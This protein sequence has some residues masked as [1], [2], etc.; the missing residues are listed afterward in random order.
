MYKVGQI[1][2]VGLREYLIIGV[3]TYGKDRARHVKD[4]ML[5]AKDIKMRLLT[6]I[7]SMS[8][9][10]VTHEI[11]TDKADREWKVYSGK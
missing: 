5:K 1:V 7:D 11:G 10:R 3:G 6:T 4:R 2:I 9:D 8:I